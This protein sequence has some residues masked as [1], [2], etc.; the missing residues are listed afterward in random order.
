MLTWWSFLVNKVSKPSKKPIFISKN[1]PKNKMSIVIFAFVQLAVGV[2]NNKTI[3][4]HFLP[5]WV[6]CQW[7]LNPTR[8]VGRK[9]LFQ[10]L[11]S[12]FWFCWFLRNGLRHFLLCT[13][14]LQGKSIKRRNLSTALYIRF[15]C[16]H[17]PSS[18]ES[19]CYS[20]RCGT[21]CPLADKSWT[22]SLFS[23]SN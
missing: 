11:I 7:D 14:S 9:K 6:G 15:P 3:S 18:L 20:D 4:K 17:L 19:K 16:V 23:F 1:L 8:L 21:E 5:I 13:G 2:K 12:K 10:C 22:I